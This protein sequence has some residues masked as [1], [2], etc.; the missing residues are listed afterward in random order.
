MVKR[1]LLALLFLFSMVQASWSG[2]VI[3]N[4]YLDLDFTSGESGVVLDLQADLIA[5]NYGQETDSNAITVYNPSNNPI[6]FQV[7]SDGVKY[8]P[9]GRVFSCQALPLPDSNIRFVKFQHSGNDA[10]Y[11]VFVFTTQTDG[12]LNSGCINARLRDENDNMAEFDSTASGED[13]VGYLVVEAMEHHK[14]HEGDHY[15]CQEDDQDVDAVKY[16]LLKA[17]DTATRVHYIFNM[18]S[19]LNG[20][21]EFFESP[22]VTASGTT[23][24]TYNNDR[25]SGNTAELLIFEDPT[26]SAEGSSRLLVNIIGSDGLN[27]N[28]SDGGITNRTTEQILGQGLYYLIVYT[29]ESSDQ[30]INMCSEWYEV[31]QE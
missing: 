23:L 10:A 13:G 1:Y 18:R 8:D 5:E 9:V 26:I 20:T 7:S 11:Q 2:P 3:M 30:R 6:D 16:F 27:P 31:V 21:I 24:T 22:T 28:G 12:V 4:S 29:P 17:P 15:T 25:N 19:S 14:I